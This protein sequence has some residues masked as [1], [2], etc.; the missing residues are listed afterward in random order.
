MTESY[1]ERSYNIMANNIFSRL[2]AMQ[3]EEW[4]DITTLSE[5]LKGFDKSTDVA[6]LAEAA[7]VERGYIERDPLTNN[8]RLTPEGRQNCATGIEIPPSDIQRL[9]RQLHM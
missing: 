8:V 1:D 3:G 6:Y 2:C 7:L 4:H 9:R 5:Q